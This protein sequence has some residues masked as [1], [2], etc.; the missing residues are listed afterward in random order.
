MTEIKLFNHIRT[1]P[2]TWAKV[3]LFLMFLLTFDRTVQGAELKKAAI[4]YNNACAA[5]SHY[6]KEQ[7]IPLLKKFGVEKI[8]KKDYI[9]D[10]SMHKELLNRSSRLGIPLKLQGH[11]TVFIDKRIILEGH[12]PE[13]IIRSLFKASNYEKI[14]VYQDSMGE[15]V[16]S[17]KVW[18]FRG[19]VKEYP[20]TTPVTEYLAWFRSNR[21]KLVR[22]KELWTV[23]QWLPVIVSTG[24]LDGINPCAFAVLLFFI[25]FLFTLKRTRTNIARVGM[26]YITV[27]YLTYLGIGLGILRALV[28]AGKPHLI[29]RLSSWLLIGLGL[30]NIK[31]YFWYGRWFSLSPSGR[32]H[33]AGTNW[34][35]KAT[36]PATAV[37]GFLVGLCTFPC[38]GGIYVAMLGL[39]SAKTTYWTGLGYLLLYNLMFVVPLIIIL[40]VLSSRRAIGQFSRWEVSRKRGIKLVTGLV[41]AAM[42]AVIL[43]WFV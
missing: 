5:C 41:M 37:G 14:L 13:R 17:Y 39:L 42:G 21:N 2:F 7:L 29:A 35:K 15:N 25:A 28:F 6:I 10:P 33:E 38:S 12:V 32:L 18:A 36:L 4:Y 27:I 19:P 26:V 9:N 24:L 43:I 16:K 23:W 30:V 8:V 22:K 40:L 20:I 11:L 3:L 1:F 34:L 31:D